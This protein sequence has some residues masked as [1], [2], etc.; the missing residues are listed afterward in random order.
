VP[1][2]E[3]YDKFSRRVK[4]SERPTSPGLSQSSAAADE[5]QKATNPWLPDARARLGMVIPLKQVDHLSRGS[6]SDNGPSYRSDELAES[7][8]GA[9]S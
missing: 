7:L 4:Y 2:Y 3:K 1:R 9:G 8:V 5:E 6:S